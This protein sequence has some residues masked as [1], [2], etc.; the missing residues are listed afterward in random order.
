MASD[1]QKCDSKVQ[2]TQPTCGPE[3]ER[4]T[5]NTTEMDTGEIQ[6]SP[7]SA[8]LSTVAPMESK[9]TPQAQ[10]EQLKQPVPLTHQVYIGAI[11]IIPALLTLLVELARPLF[12]PLAALAALWVTRVQK[13][14]PRH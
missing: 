3:P 11:L 14:L 6:S 8:T 9:S 1:Q 4:L 12:I 13:P 5:E 7:V 2:I 10:D